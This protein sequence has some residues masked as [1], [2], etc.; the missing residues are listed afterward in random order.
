MK[1]GFTLLIVLTRNFLLRQ[2]AQEVTLSVCP[3]VCDIFEFFTLSKRELLRLVFSTLKKTLFYNPMGNGQM[4]IVP[5][6]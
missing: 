6:K 3:C 1:I 5:L 2:E 4:G